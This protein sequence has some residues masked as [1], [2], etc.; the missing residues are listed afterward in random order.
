M[1]QILLLMTLKII[2]VTKNLF[3]NSNFG[4]GKTMSRAPYIYIATKAMFIRT[5]ILLT[6]VLVNL[7][8]GVTAL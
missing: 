1:S 8:K 4:I 6:K 5:Y 3:P 7:K 2:S